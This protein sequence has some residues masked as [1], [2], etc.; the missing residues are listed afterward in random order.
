MWEREFS[1]ESEVPIAVLERGFTSEETVGKVPGTLSRREVAS[2]ATVGEILKGSDE[3][4]YGL[5]SSQRSIG[6]LTKR[7]YVISS[8]K[9]LL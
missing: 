3:C 7:K 9:R 1:G 8:G 4:E 5:L 6:R 2:K